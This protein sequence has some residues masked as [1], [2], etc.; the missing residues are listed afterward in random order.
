MSRVSSA[1]SAAIALA[2]WP[3]LHVPFKG[4]PEALTQVASGQVDF[5]S[6]GISCGCTTLRGIEPMPLEPAAFDALIAKETE[7]NRQIVKAAG[8]K[9]N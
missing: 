6:I 8:L 4:G 7:S 9:F 2:S 1:D 5:M 3:S